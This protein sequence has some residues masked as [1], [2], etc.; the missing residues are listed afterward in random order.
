MSVTTPQINPTVSRLRCSKSGQEVSIGNVRQCPGLCSCCPA[1]GKPLVVEYDRAHV[2]AA[3]APSAAP[4]AGLFRF[5]AGLPVVGLAPGYAGD[6]GDTPVFYHPRLS[7]EL[8]VEV[9]LKNESRNPSGSFKD[10]G[11]AMGIALGVAFGARRFC[12]PTQGNAGVSAAMFSARLGLPGALVYM[13]DGYQGSIYHQACRHFGGEVVFAGENIAGAGKV[14]RTALEAP[15]ARGEYVDISTFF[16]PGRL[17]GKKTMGFEI[18]EAFAGNPLPDVIFYPTGGG[19]GLVGIWKA[20]N[21]LRDWGLSDPAHT[22]LPRLVAV[23]SDRC[24]P[25]VAAFEAGARDVTPVVS[26]R[27]VADGL[28]VPGAIMGHAMLDALRE[29]GGVA[30]AVA[31]VDIES[32]FADFGQ[33]GLGAGYESAATL[34]A[35]REARRSGAIQAGAKVLLLLTGSHLVPLSMSSARDARRGVGS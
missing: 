14:M 12:L 22:R 6:V 5:A 11:L 17:E 31:D 7:E 29:S 23:Q 9:F 35:L 4:S 13:P 2:R 19:T 33:I 8:D 24:A 3:W 18:A 25:V 34:A 15:L 20:L 28:D 32:A 27:T 21:E 26:R 10:R 1:P 16:E 30:L